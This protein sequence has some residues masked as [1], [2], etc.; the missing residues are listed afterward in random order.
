MIKLHPKSEIVQF[1]HSSGLAE[2]LLNEGSGKVVLQIEP[3]PHA[4]YDFIAEIISRNDYK[5]GAV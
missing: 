3:I 5:E 4:K 1:H 2:K